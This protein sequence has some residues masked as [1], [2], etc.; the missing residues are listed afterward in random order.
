MTKPK[1]DAER[2]ERITMEIVVDAYG[3]EEQAMGWYCYLQDTMQFPF[4]ATCIKQRSVSPLKLGMT[5][6]AIGIADE[7]ECARE[8]FVEISWDGDDVL[9]VPLMQL[10]AAPDAA[11]DNQQAVEDW[12]YWHNQ[13]Y[14]FG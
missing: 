4:Q 1:R 6:E 14:Q 3:P 10:S 5:V 13:G 9:A 7:D 12:H 8:I 11:A 2:E